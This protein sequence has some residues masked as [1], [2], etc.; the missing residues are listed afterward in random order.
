M[1]QRAIPSLLEV[2][3]GLTDGSVVVDVGS[4]TG[5]PS[6]MFLRKG[7]RVFAVEPDE[8]MG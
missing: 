7:N 6:G 2:E 8:E 1:Y 4:G 5:I 3:C